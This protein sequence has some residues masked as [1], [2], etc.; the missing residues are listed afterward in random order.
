MT[1]RMAESAKSKPVLPSRARILRRLAPWLAGGALLAASAAGLWWVL[2]RDYARAAERGIALLSR[3]PRMTAVDEALAQWADEFSL[4]PASAARVADVLFERHSLEDARVRRLLRYLTGADFGA[5][6]DDWRRWRENQ[7]RLLANQQPAVRSGE[8]VTLTHKWQAPVGLTDWRTVLAPIDGFIYVASLGAGVERSDDRFDGVVRV[9]GRDGRAELLFQSPRLDGDLAGIAATEDGLFVVTAAGAA[10]RIDAGGQALWQT[11]FGERVVSLPLSVDVNRNGVSDLVVAT[12]HGR[13]V[14][15]SGVN[16]RA[17]WTRSV[18]SAAG[19]QQRDGLG[20][21]AWLAVGS[22]PG[23]DVTLWLATTGGLVAALSARNGRVQG[24]ATIPAGASGPL[25]VIERA[26]TGPTA[27]VPCGDGWIR[28]AALERDVTLT[29]RW[30]LGAPAAAGLAMLFPMG[31]ESE[32]RALA[33]GPSDT[34][35]CAAQLVAFDRV[36]SSWRL[37]LERGL[38]GGAVLAD[39]NGDRRPELL[40]ATIERGL[41]ASTLWAI[42]SS[43]QALVRTRLP[44]RVV[45]APVVAD[46]D[47]DG[48]L[49]V[50]LADAAGLLHCFSTGQAGEV[51]WGMLSGDVRNTFNARNAYAYSQTPCGFQWRWRPER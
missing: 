27:C 49:D 48:L 43:G 14:A 29:P 2:R 9:D 38:V 26:A 5:R 17:I 34:P 21:P 33:I 7:Q 37:G 4:A 47:G 1:C 45:S 6:G 41:R 8:R 22:A 28:A 35:M 46:V 40:V 12:E 36:A 11:T 32:A 39:L 20:A 30:Q 23:G 13:V 16:G 42:S 24:S 25:A 19:F 15:I 44:F 3:A 50:L 18:G 31:D 10:W 51:I